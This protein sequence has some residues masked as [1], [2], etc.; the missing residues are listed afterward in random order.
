MR[1]LLMVDMQKDFLPG[2]ALAVKGGETLIPLLNKLQSHFDLIVA[3][4]DWHPQNHMSFASTHGKKVG[5]EITLFGTAQKLWPEHCLQ[6]SDGAEFGLGLDVTR[7]VNVF[8]KGT[9]ASMDSY[10]AFFDN[11]H[12]RQTGLEAFLKEK[13]VKE[14]FIAGLTTEYCVKYTALDACRLGF[15]VT[16]ILDGCLG[17]ELE[18]GDTE[19]AIKE[20]KRAGAHFIFSKELLV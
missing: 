20:M 14:L 11:A 15:H 9:E 2:G 1:A 18:K 7:V 19:R 12:L 5:D 8:Y 13:H 17:I 4:K 16:V 10:S 3:T 6:G